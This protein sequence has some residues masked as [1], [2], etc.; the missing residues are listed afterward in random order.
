MPNEN[1]N[2]RKCNK[3]KQQEAV[4]SVQTGTRK[5]SKKQDVGSKTKKASSVEENQGNDFASIVSKDGISSNW[6]TFRQN[7]LHLE[8][9]GAARTENKNTYHGFRQKKSAENTNQ[10]STS[11]A[12]LHRRKAITGSSEQKNKSYCYGL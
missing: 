4:D 11:S 9:D 6:K 5:Q 2:F 8:K 7:L 1:G 3:K 12:A 10:A